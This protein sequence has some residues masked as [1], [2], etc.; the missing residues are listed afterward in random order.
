[1]RDVACTRVLPR[2]TLAISCSPTRS[3]HSE[4]WPHRRP[5]VPPYLCSVETSGSFPSSP[6]SPV[7][8]KPK[9]HSSARLSVGKGSLGEETSCVPQ[10]RR[11]QLKIAALLFA[12]V[13]PPSFPHIFA[14]AL[15]H[16]KA[17]LNQPPLKPYPSK[18]H[19]DQQL[20]QLLICCNSCKRSYSP[21]S[22]VGA[23]LWAPDEAHQK[24][25][26]PPQPSLHR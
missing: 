9:H 14:I 17:I 11:T 15:P 18:N 20:L 7:K 22:P 8:P 6:F 10:G 12:T 21:V 19:C 5:G 25:R 23:R 16:Y 4:V 13:F 2:R 3:A 1:V 24:H 26:K